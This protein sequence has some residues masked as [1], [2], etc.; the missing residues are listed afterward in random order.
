MTYRKTLRVMA[1]SCATYLSYLWQTLQIMLICSQGVAQFYSSSRAHTD[2]INSEYCYDRPMRADELSIWQ[3]T[4]V[5]NHRHKWKTNR[6]NKQTTKGSTTLTL[7]TL[8]TIRMERTSPIK[9]TTTL[10]WNILFCFFT[11]YMTHA[12]LDTKTQRT[13]L[14]TWKLLTAQYGPRCCRLIERQTHHGTVPEARHRGS[15]KRRRRK[16]KLPHFRHATNHT[17]YIVRPD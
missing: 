17:T 9:K 11:K 16:R 8:L 1:R 14:K 7:T 2:A 4:V 10:L 6:T 12:L 13:G 5:W 15:R 3:K